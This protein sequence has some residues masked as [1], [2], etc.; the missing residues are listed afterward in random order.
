M[1]A[2]GIKQLGDG[3]TQFREQQFRS[4]APTNSGQAAAGALITQIGKLTGIAIQSAKD[5]AHASGVLELRDLREGW[6]ASRILTRERKIKEQ[7][8][9]KDNS[10]KYSPSELLKIVNEAK[11]IETKTVRDAS[12]TLRNTSLTGEF[13]DQDK[14]EPLDPLDIEMLEMFTQYKKAKENA[15]TGTQS[16]EAF[17]TPN[18]KKMSS[19]QQE[20]F[21]KAT[22]EMAFRINDLFSAGLRNARNPMQSVGSVDADKAL[23]E[24]RFNEFK[25]IY[26][27]I[28]TA[29]TGPIVMKYVGTEITIDAPEK[30]LDALNQDLR[31]TLGRN[32]MHTAI[33][34]PTGSKMMG[35]MSTARELVS[36]ISRGM[37]DKNEVGSKAKEK[38]LRMT[39][40]NAMQVIKENNIIAGLPPD[41]QESAAVAK[42]LRY[43][44]QVTGLVREI[45]DPTGTFTASAL[46]M[47]MAPYTRRHWTKVSSGLAK[48]DNPAYVD[49]LKELSTAYIAPGDLESHL[50]SLNKG[51]ENMLKNYPEEKQQERIRHNFNKVISKFERNL[52]L[53]VEEKL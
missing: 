13:L 14:D 53:K 4:N 26:D 5:N 25:S 10:E 17:Y 27:G 47:A 32:N 19:S 51:L 2:G 52:K 36:N 8:W 35:M 16:W 42:H 12:G 1:V 22:T 20:E 37:M 9:I 30:F 31:N 18:I 23:A 41:V 50:S 44:A 28:V 34:D 24:Q 46:S 33:G 43:F 40:S 49:V 11:A 7:Q 3:P 45:N 29:A 38:S 48:G 39:V 6:V 21:T 15:P